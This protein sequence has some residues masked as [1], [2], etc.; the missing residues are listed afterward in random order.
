MRSAKSDYFIECEQIMNEIDKI[1]CGVN[2]AIYTSFERHRF[3]WGIRW[4]FEIGNV[5][6]S[7]ERSSCGFIL[8]WHFSEICLHFMSTIDFS[9]G[10]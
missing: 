3:R 1:V 2:R 10:I 4:K 6:V 5:F 8:W 9:K 7:A